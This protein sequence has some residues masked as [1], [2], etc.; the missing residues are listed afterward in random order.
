MF[1]RKFLASKPLR[2]Q[3]INYI[4]TNVVQKEY[5]LGESCIRIKEKE[6]KIKTNQP[7]LSDGSNCGPALILNT[8]PN[9]FGKKW[10]QSH[11]IFP[12]W[13]IDSSTNN[14]INL[15]VIFW[16]HNVTLD[17][18]NSNNTIAQSS[19]MDSEQFLFPFQAVDCWFVYKTHSMLRGVF[20]WQCIH[21]LNR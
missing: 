18:F 10:S 14:V 2:F 5:F 6:K 11:L 21:T 17:P 8:F 13:Q 1:D 16:A 19:K 15:L 9:P 7:F 3:I 4:L 20:T 12:K